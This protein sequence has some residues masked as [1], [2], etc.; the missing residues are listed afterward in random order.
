[1]QLRKGDFRVF[2]VFD[3]GATTTKLKKERKKK[4][5]GK[6]IQSHRASFSSSFQPSESFLLHLVR[7]ISPLLP[8]ALLLQ[9]RMALLRRGKAKKHVFWCQFCQMPTDARLSFFSHTAIFCLARCRMPS[10][11]YLFAS[12]ID[13]CLS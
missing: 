5:S 4:R 1:M 8:C 7:T 9:A 2:F 13:G 10:K 3:V 6:S 12:C 11:G